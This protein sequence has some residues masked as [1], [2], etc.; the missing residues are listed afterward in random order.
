MT[1]HINLRPHSIA[2]F[3]R[4]SAL[5]IRGM[6]NT[7]HLRCSFS[8]PN[9]TNGERSLP[10]SR[11]E[12][13]TLIELTLATAFIAFILIFMLATMIQVMSNYNKGLAVKQINQTARTVSEEMG[14]LIQSTS[15]TAINTA[16]I[17]NGRVCL[18]GVSYVWNVNGATTNKYTTGSSFTM[19][20]VN[21]AAGA[22]CSSGLPAVNPSNAS[23]LLSTNIWVQQVNVA[24]SSNQKLVDITIGLSTAA[25]NQPTGTDAI[26]GTICDGGKDSQYCAVATFKTTVS[27]KDGGG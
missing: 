18:G 11:S 3:G 14:Q 16:Y 7:A 4:K 2:R 17:S 15:A 6:L 22:L 12:G 24:V 26:L 9:R 13:F 25:P 23:E 21:D 19:V 8:A 10:Q 5:R 20:R 1:Q 27:T